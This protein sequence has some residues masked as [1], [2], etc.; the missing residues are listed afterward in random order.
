MPSYPGFAMRP[1]N[2]HAR[3][4][5]SEFGA[6][7]RLLDHTVPMRARRQLIKVLTEPFTVVESVSVAL[8]CSAQEAFDFMWDPDTSRVL[9]DD[10]FHGTRLAGTPERAV[11]EVQ[12]FLSRTD[13]VVHGTMMEVQSLA[14]GRQAVTRTI[15]DTLENHQLLDIL[16]LDEESCRLTQEFSTVVPAGASTDYVAALRADHRRTLDRLATTLV[17]RFGPGQR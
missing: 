15:S 6:E 11:G 3:P 14:E 12:V 8:G 9:N 10:A 16:P 7:E 4:S 13:G 17:G 1:A 2:R 5:S